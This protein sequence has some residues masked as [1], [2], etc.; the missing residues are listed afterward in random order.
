MVD[1]LK[2]G[3]ILYHGS[4]C[5]VEIPVLEK[6][7]NYK[8]FGRG[9]YLTTDKRQA[10]S[11]ARISLRKAKENGLVSE[12]QQFGFVNA[13]RFDFYAD[14]K[15]K[16]Y[17]DADVEW[18][19]CIVAHRRKSAFR[20]ILEENL[21]YDIIGG[22]IANDATNLT[23]VAYMSGAYGVM[24]SSGADEKIN[25]VLEQTSLCGV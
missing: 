13:F 18:L 1:S 9:F 14:L 7:S 15:I 25:F 8:D 17:P 20:N 24:G 5:A 16:V 22:K 4:Y 10:E 3:T 12:T 6:C 19:H 11:F 2:D 21:K 23:L